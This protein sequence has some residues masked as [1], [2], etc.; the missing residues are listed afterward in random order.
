MS[1]FTIILTTGVVLY[2]INLLYSLLNGPAV[3]NREDPWGS[4]RYGLPDVIPP[5][6][7]PHHSPNPWPFI[8]ATGLIPLGL[9]VLSLLKGVSPILQN[10]PF[11]SAPQFG[12]VAIAVFMSLGVAWFLADQVKHAKAL[13]MLNGAHVEMPKPPTLWGDLRLSM[14]WIILSEV[15][16]FG[17]LISSAYYARVVLFD[18]WNAALTHLPSLIGPLSLAMTFALWGSSFTAMAARRS[19]Q[20]GNLRQFY[21]WLAV[22]TAL[23]AFF[24]GS[25][26]LVEYPALQKEGFTPASSIVANYFYAIVTLHGFHVIIGLVFWS[27]VAV[28]V[29]LGYWSQKRPQGVEAAEYYWHFVDGVWVVLFVTFYLGAIHAIRPVP[30]AA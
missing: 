2:F 1:I 11:L 12:L 27:L 15:A 30:T 23:G 25:Q 18:N 7:K 17:T 14:V 16:L 26:F 3:K 5:L 9:G 8:L 19:L 29:A 24:A 6:V 13:R 21:L 10:Y 28:L 20:R 4:A 22:T